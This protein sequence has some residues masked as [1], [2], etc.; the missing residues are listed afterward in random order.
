MSQTN[1]TY[2]YDGNFW[3]VTGL[4]GAVVLILTYLMFYSELPFFLLLVIIIVVGVIYGNGPEVL[5]PNQQAVVK[6][7]NE[8]T[9]IVTKIG[10]YIWVTPFVD[11]LIVYEVGP[12]LLDIDYSGITLGD[13]DTLTGKAQLTFRINPKYFRRIFFIVGEPFTRERLMSVV[14]GKLNETVQSKLSIATKSLVVK[15]GLDFESRTQDKDGELVKLLTSY[16]IDSDGSCFGLELIK[17]ELPPPSYSGV[18]AETK[19]AIM[20]QEL[21]KTLATAE[22][23]T[24][25]D[26]LQSEIEFEM[27]HLG[28]I[29]PN[30]LTEPQLKEVKERAERLYN[31]NPNTIYH[32][33]LGNNTI[34]A[35]K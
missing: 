26:F 12:F 2:D 17:V 19:I 34:I 11:E 28:I 14:K 33:G 16:L 6:R 27:K 29:S 18:V 32:Q 20:N 5:E 7:F 30:R 3:F 25:Q 23:K 9:D 24:W 22:A 31:K 4:I 35:S 8:L 13:G 15:D 1:D 10:G 21:K